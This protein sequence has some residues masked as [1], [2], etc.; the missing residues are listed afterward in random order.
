MKGNNMQK[1]ISK[2][3]FVLPE[4]KWKESKNVM[5]VR[6]V[7]EEVARICKE[8]N[9]EH[10]A[11]FGSFAKGLSHPTSDIDFIVY[12]CNDFIE[13]ENEIE[14]QLLTIRKINLFDYDDICS[15]ELLED[16]KEYAIQIY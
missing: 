11:L 1:S 10:L 4:F 16:I 7:I 8:D 2:N 3:D 6:T 15:E 14:D 12:G 13:L 5:P 9:V